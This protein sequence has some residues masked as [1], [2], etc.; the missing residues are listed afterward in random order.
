MRVL[1]TVMT[2][3]SIVRHKLGAEDWYHFYNHYS[4]LGNDVGI[5][6]DEE[7]PDDSGNGRN[8]RLEDNGDHGDDL[9]ITRAASNRRLSFFNGDGRSIK[10]RV[11]SK[12]KSFVE[13][14][15]E[16]S[17]GSKALEIASQLEQLDNIS[18]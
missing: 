9:A 16:E 3:R 2:L 7:N 4:K 11:I 18:L 15:E 8:S 10:P 17:D 1:K 14:S 13:S 5:L 12:R 6:H